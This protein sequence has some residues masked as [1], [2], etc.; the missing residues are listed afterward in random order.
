MG[1]EERNNHEFTFLML[2]NEE[3]LFSIGIFI[4]R[5]QGMRKSINYDIKHLL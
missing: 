4:V 2:T 5:R 1:K 3:G